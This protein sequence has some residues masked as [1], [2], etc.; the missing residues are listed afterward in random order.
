[1]VP[2]GDAATKWGFALR[3]MI[4]TR[5]GSN[6]ILDP[7]Y[8]TTDY[9][10]VHNYV[11][12]TAARKLQT[13]PNVGDF[14]DYVD[15][16]VANGG[17]YHDIGL[18]W[19]ARLASPTGLFA[20]ENALTPDGG[21]IQR[22]IIFMTDGDTHTATKDYAAYGIGWFDRRQ[23]D[24][25]TTPTI[26]LLDDQVDARFNT[27]CKKIK[28]TNSFTLWVIAFGDVTTDTETKLT[29]CATSGRYFRAKK[30]SELQAAFKSIAD[31]ISM[32]RLTK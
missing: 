22:N 17:T 7:I 4:F 5:Q 24:P 3:D 15:G 14:E 21:E 32:L 6:L 27:L 31:Q 28:N 23:T 2:T 19:G 29:N 16:L 12:P 10:S 8:T 13:W 20:T 9:G 11:C 30:D 18:L 1:M 26:P 25:A